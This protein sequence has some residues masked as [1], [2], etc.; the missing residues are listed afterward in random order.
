MRKL[1][2][3][4]R[5]KSADWRAALDE[6]AAS[7]GQSPDRVVAETDG[8]DLAEGLYLKH[9]DGDRVIGR[10]KFI[11]ES[12]LQAV[13]TSGSHWQDRPIVP[14]RLAPGVDIFAGAGA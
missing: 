3:A 14:N 4:A 13:S 10:Y 12:F 6:A 8:S 11:R 7:A 5:F 1:V 2:G 9:E